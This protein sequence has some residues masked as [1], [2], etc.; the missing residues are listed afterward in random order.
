MADSPL[1]PDSDREKAGDPI[2]RRNSLGQIANNHVDLPIGTQFD[3]LTVIGGERRAGKNYVVTCRCDCGREIEARVDGLTSGK[4]LQCGDHARRITDAQRAALSERNRTHGM[5]GIPEYNAWCGI[6]MRCLN[7]N[8]DRFA[9][10]GGRGISVCDRWRNSFEAF[11]ADMGPRPSPKHSIDRIDV[12]GNYEP[13]NVRWADGSTQTK[14]R[15]PFLMSPGAG[16]KLAPLLPPPEYIAPPQR[17]QSTHHNAT[18]GMVRSPEY[19]AWRSMKKRCLDPNHPAYR[20]YGA[21]GITVHPEWQGNFVAFLADVGMRPSGGYSLDR[22]DNSKGYA[23]GNV[24]WS[25]RMTQNR[26]RRPFIIKSAA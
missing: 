8:N 19:Q 5:A 14:N 2:R 9:D 24:R 21:R 11:Y 20:N 6:K 10:Y 7:P 23:P 16:K 1:C 4:K 13:G 22:I 17:P 25:D 15:R 12:D 3:R 26:N 18:H